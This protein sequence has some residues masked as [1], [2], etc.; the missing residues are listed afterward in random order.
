MFLWLLLIVRC[1]VR[2]R[3][4]MQSCSIMEFA[5]CLLDVGCWMLV[6]QD[7]VFGRLRF[8]GLVGS[9]MPCQQPRPTQKHRRHIVEVNKPAS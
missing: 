4:C 6:K 2:C 8:L 9:W 3:C 5:D 1:G 7:A